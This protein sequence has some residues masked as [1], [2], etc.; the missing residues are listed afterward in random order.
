MLVF[1]RRNLAFLA[2]PKTG[3]TAAEMTLRKHAEIVFRGRL[4]HMTARKFHR[5][6]A[7]FLQSAYG[8]N[9]ERMAVMREP[10]EQLR[11][12]Y[13]YRCAERLKG[14]KKATQNIS[15]DEFVLAAIDEDPPAFANVGSQFNFLTSV[16]GNVLVH[17][18]FAHTQQSEMLEFLADRLHR[19][20][21]FDEV[22][23]SPPVD[24]SLSPEVGKTTASGANRGF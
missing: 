24:A 7:P 16:H 22:N 23:K 20:L 5:H 1:L 12:W 8:V 6:M 3:T 13:R 17:H 11:S 4:K 21:E 15:F 14:S 19:D 2:V 9:P 10:V 18:L